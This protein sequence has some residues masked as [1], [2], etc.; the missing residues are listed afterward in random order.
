MSVLLAAALP[1]ATACVVAFFLYQ[2]RK[3]ARL[4]HERY[5]KAVDLAL[6]HSAGELQL[7]RAAAVERRSSTSSSVMR[8]RA[9][10]E[11][12]LYSLAIEL[13]MSGQPAAT[14]P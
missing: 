10:E 14:T 12:A 7:L 2:R 4:G 8:E 11:C 3:T 13:K 6:T 9:K 1:A 5:L